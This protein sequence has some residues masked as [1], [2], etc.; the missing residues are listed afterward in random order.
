MNIGA[1][2]II[3]HII[4]RAKTIP[5]VDELMLCTSTEKSDDVLEEIAKR[6]NI[7]VF[8][9]SLTDVLVRFQGAAQKFGVT[10]FA[11]YTADNV[12][13]DP[14]LIGLGLV[15]MI[16]NG[17][18]FIDLPDCCLAYGGAAYC[19]STAALNKVCKTKKTESTEY[20]QKFFRAGNFKCADLKSDDPVFLGS[21]IR[22]T[23]DYPEDLEFARRVFNELKIDIN[24]IPLRRVLDLLQQKP[25]ITLIN[26]FRQE[27]WNDNQKPMKII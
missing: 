20:Y 2:P 1:K 19:I 11:V 5:C 23:L 15:Q 18:D 21:K 13:C 17:L 22:L 25:E 10:H 27:S 9:G 6:N 26:N 3:Q 14:N 24:D 12:F 8:R 4:E 7:S 16:E